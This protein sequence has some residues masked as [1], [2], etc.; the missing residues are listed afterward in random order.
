MKTTPAT[1][2]SLL[3]IY[4]AVA[5]GVAFAG[6]PKCGTDTQS[7]LDA[8]ARHWNDRGWVGIEMEQDLENGRITVTRVV[9]GSPA[10]GSG[11]RVGDVLIALDGVPFSE[12]TRE[13]MYEVRQDWHIGRTVRYT[14]QRGDKTVESELTLGR[15]PDEFLASWIGEHM[16]EHVTPENKGDD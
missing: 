13:K 14:I 7:C 11:M 1:I 4:A 3:L 2:A 5:S 9:P 15:L 8:M 12:K 6:E 16:L 10:A